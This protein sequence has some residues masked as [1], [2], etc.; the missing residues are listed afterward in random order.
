MKLMCYLIC[1]VMGLLIVGCGGDEDEPVIEDKDIPPPP[2]INLIRSEPP[3]GSIISLSTDLGTPV[4]IQLFFDRLPSYVSVSGIQ[5]QLQD[6]HVFWE[7]ST[8][9]F[10]DALKPNPA[11]KGGADLSVAWINPDGSDGEAT[12]TFIAGF[13][14][15]PP[16][17]IS[18]TVLDGDSDVDPDVLNAGIRFDF[19]REVSGNITIQPED[20]KPFDWI[21][22]FAGKTVTLTPIAGQEVQHGVVYV[23]HIEVV[24]IIEE[25]TEFTITF[26]TKDE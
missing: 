3:K 21:V 24:S 23:I 19:D 14:G 18:G 8:Q 10:L 2:P 4:E 16:E 20:G 11:V 6:D 1:F 22:S 12:L 13:G 25:K 9:Q 7:V 5:A 15:N 26:R 17:M